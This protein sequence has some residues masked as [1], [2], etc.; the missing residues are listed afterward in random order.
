MCE[1]TSYA[2]SSGL[3]ANVDDPAKAADAMQGSAPCARGDPTGATGVPEPRPVSIRAPAQG[4]TRMT[5]RGKGNV[6]PPMIMAVNVGTD[7]GGW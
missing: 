5:A 2:A 4:A 6:S 1:G 7:N 3:G